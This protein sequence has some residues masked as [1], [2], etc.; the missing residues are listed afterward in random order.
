[1]KAFKDSEAREWPISVTVDVIERVREIDVDLGDVSAATMRQIALDDVLLVRV[2]WI[3]VEPIADTR[4]VTADQFGSAMVGKPLE[5]AYDS[6]RG[7]IEDFFPPRKRGFWTA[8]VNAD[9]ASQ[10]EAM[11]MG[12]EALE[13]TE[14]KAAVSEAMRA[15]LKAEMQKTLTQLKS[16]TGSPDLS[17]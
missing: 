13:D 10:A 6:L 3:I 8:A 2:L 17:E 4:G 9:M 1:M 16:A 5:D 11:A 14:T 12:I 15:R 7:A